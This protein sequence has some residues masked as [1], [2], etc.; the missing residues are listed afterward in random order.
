LYF[1]L[2]G[3]LFILVHAPYGVGDR[4][5][6][7]SPSE[8]TSIDGSSGWVVERVALYTTSLYWPATNERCTINN[9]AISN[10]RI[11]NLNRSPHAQLFIFMKFSID[12]PYEKFQI[13]SA[14]LEQ[15]CKDRPREWQAFITF[16]P[17]DAAVEGNYV[18][19]NM[20]I[21]THRLSWQEAGDVLQSKSDFVTYQ[22]EVAKQLGIG[23]RQPSLPVDVNINN[24]NNG[25]PELNNAQPK[26]GELGPMEL[27]AMSR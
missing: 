14:A 13:A 25:M 3:V 21:A 17:A 10:Y 22:L 12:T 18:S 4:V 23:Y 15:Y 16:R 5:H 8:G 27:E 20:T 26:S 1:Y 19:Y 6:F 2:Q 7:S 24:T 9:G 11:I